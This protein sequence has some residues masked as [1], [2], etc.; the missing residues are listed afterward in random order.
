MIDKVY[1]QGI[2]SKCQI[3]RN[4]TKGLRNKLT[5]TKNNYKN[6]N[7]ICCKETTKFPV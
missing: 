3:M 2:D 6:W 1:F 4:K 7:S 5:S